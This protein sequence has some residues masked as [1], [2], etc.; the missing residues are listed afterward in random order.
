MVTLAL[1]IAACGKQ[2]A[3]EYTAKFV[4][5]SFSCPSISLCVAMGYG[6]TANIQQHKVARSTTQRIVWQASVLPGTIP[7]SE[8]SGSVSCPNTHHCVAVNFG[9][10]PE[11]QVFTTTDGGM[12]WTQVTVPLGIGTAWSITCPTVNRCVMSGYGNDGS[13]IHVS[14]NGGRTWSAVNGGKIR[15]MLRDV[16]CGSPNVCVAVGTDGVEVTHDGGATWQAAILP[17]AWLFNS[18]SCAD[19]NHCV[20]VGLGGVGVANSEPTALVAFSSTGGEAW[21]KASG[22]V[23]GTEAASVSCSTGT[24][25]ALVIVQ[26]P[27][28]HTVPLLSADSGVSWTIGNGFGTHLASTVKCIDSSFCIA[29]NLQARGNSPSVFVTH[30]GGH[31]WSP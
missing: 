20:A 8:G 29:N 14:S 15:G 13:D 21:H 2:P 28:R 7:S 1:A 3:P 26:S 12:E 19:G 17:K 6:G 25:V 4:P 11:P 30:S 9:P 23:V 18:V 27:T 31:T 24:C 16:S 10:K 5:T 22:P